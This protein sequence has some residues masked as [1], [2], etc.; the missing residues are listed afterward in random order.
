MTGVV[1]ARYTLE[2]KQ[3]AVE[4]PEEALALYLE[5]LDELSKSIPE[6]RGKTTSLSRGGIPVIA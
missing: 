4:H 1:R 3:E 2:F 5:M 6:E